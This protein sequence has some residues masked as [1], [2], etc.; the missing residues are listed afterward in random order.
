MSGNLINMIHFLINGDE[1]QIDVDPSTPLLWVVRDH[2]QLTGSKFGCGM[3]LCGACT[4]LMDDQAI[5]SCVMP[6]SAIEGKSITT[7]EGLGDNHPVQQAWVNH[8]VPQCGYCQSGQIMSTLAI[9]QRN[10][11]PTEE[12][13]KAGLAGNICRCGTYQYILAAAMEAAENIQAGNF[14]DAGEQSTHQEN[15]GRPS[16]ENHA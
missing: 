1:V 16:D 2:L 13:L 14:Y 15:T 5:R 8:S 12:E 4:M 9:L 11:N 6:I 7:I 3:G 10:P